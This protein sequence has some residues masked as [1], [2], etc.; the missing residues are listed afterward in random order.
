MVRSSRDECSSTRQSVQRIADCGFSWP[1]EGHFMAEGLSVQ[2]RK[3][4]YPA[5]IR[6]LQAISLADCSS[7][8]RVHPVFLLANGAHAP[9]AFPATANQIWHARYLKSAWQGPVDRR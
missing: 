6:R 8:Q 3:S 2:R 9:N 4:N 7:T 1:H 5:R